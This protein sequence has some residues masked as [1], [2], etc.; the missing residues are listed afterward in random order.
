MVGDL[1]VGV[2]AP[3]FDLP[4]IDGKNLSLG[5]FRKG[6][7]AV[8]VV[9]FCNHCPYCLAYEERLL[10]LQSQ[11]SKKGVAFIRIN[12]DDESSHPEDTFEEMKKRAAGKGADFIY[13]KDMEGATARTF[14]AKVV[15]E[16]FLL[17]SEGAVRYAGRIDDCWQSLKRVRRHDLREALE[18]VL[19]DRDVAVKSTRA[20][21]CAIKRAGPG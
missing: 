11:Y 4:G 18:A 16:A 12:P 19:Q 1:R 8:V 2:Q 10:K 14:G 15:P 7:N 13:F 17:D 5:S 9:F 20:V 3:E 6:K 21:G